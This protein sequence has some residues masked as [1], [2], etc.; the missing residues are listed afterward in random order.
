M[1]HAHTMRDHALT[2]MARPNQPTAITGRRRAIENSKKRIP[3]ILGKLAIAQ[4]SAVSRAAL[5]D[6]STCIHDALLKRVESRFGTPLS[7]IPVDVYESHTE[8]S[9]ISRVSCVRD[10]AVWSHLEK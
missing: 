6:W 7:H 9:L 4:L 10:V 2:E 5:P 1:A 8:S 3:E